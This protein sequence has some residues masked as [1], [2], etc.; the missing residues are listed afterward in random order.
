MSV[1]FSSSCCSSELACLAL[2]PA[3][4]QR[5]HG[6]SSSL[7]TAPRDTPSV[8]SLPSLPYA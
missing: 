4:A 3:R 8:H 1:S 5:M 2:G 7:P 6:F